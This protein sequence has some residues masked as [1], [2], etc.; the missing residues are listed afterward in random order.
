MESIIFFRSLNESIF[1]SIKRTKLNFIRS[2]NFTA[3]KNEILLKVL[4]HNLV[5][6]ANSR[7]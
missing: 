5:V 4:C 6:L 1:S 2:K 3:G 7:D